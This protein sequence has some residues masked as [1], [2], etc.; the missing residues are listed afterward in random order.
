MMAGAAG[1]DG[2]YPVLNAAVAAGLWAKPYTP[3]AVLAALAKDALGPADL[4]AL[5]SPAAE[6]FLEAM[7]QKARDITLRLFGRT[8]QF[9]APLYL[10]DFCTN[11]CLYCG[12][13]A[14]R[15][16]ARKKL[17]LSE[18]KEQGQS[19]AATGLRRILALTGDDAARTGADYLAD[20]V[21]VLARQFSSVGIEVPALGREEY[22]KV[23]LAGADSLTMFQETYNEALYA[24]VHPAGPKRDFR[25]RLD[26]PERA[27]QGGLRG[28]TLGP[29]LGLDDWRREVLLCALHADFLARRYP[30]LEIGL[31]FPRLRPCGG[32]SDNLPAPAFTPLPVADRHLA[33]AMAAFRC[34]MPQAGIT[35][36]TREGAALRDRLIPLGVTRLSA[37]VST[38]VGG[39]VA[40][41]AQ[42][43]PQFAISD[44]RSVA[45]VVR[46]V[47]ARGY[48]AVF[49]DRLLFAPEDHSPLAGREEQ[50]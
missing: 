50:P 11:G 49:E 21:G 36:S 45:E 31:S 15:G 2:F 8:V 40:A 18:V 32:A 29:L 12:F 7:A 16:F 3:Q 39:Y 42:S 22:A 5:L 30:W 34:F 33:Q 4:A 13:N 38:T 19:I 47:T 6:P 9:F 35:L 10:A 44:P 17:S 27:A 43:T 1:N 48:Q 26:A 37:G 25:H 14:S 24:Q 20:C 23:A 28:V 41:Q 46:A